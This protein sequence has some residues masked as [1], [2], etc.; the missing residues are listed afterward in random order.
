MRNDSR[1]TWLAAVLAIAALAVVAWFVLRREQRP[2]A[3]ARRD[4]ER[5][6]LGTSQPEP[7]T[8]ESDVDQRAEI[9]RVLRLHVTTATQAPISGA[10][11]R[12]SS[13]SGAALLGTTDATGTVQVAMAQLISGLR[14]SA[15]GFRAKEVELPRPLPDEL[16]VVL[17]AL[18]CI[19]GRVQFAGGNPPSVATVIAFPTGAWPSAHDVASRSDLDKVETDLT[20]MFE[21]CDLP[22]G[23][24]W[25]LLAGCQGYATPEAAENVA[26]DQPPV[27]LALAAY[28]FFAIEGALE[29]DSRHAVC[30]SCEGD[31]EHHPLQGTAETLGRHTARMVRSGVLRPARRAPGTRGSEPRGNS[32]P[33]HGRDARL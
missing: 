21:F 15:N 11:V 25:T 33:L 20:G 16:T 28:D 26:P 32:D 4:L 3:E 24:R 1:R 18:G 29:G 23:S 10:S 13:S 30:S 27:D 31:E 2:A 14:V 9:A 5:T 8:S 6:E 12:N 19:A 17:E 7:R 22:A